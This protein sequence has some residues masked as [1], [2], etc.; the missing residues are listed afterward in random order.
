MG[1]IVFVVAVCAVV[2]VLRAFMKWEDRQMNTWTVIAEGEFDHVEVRR[3]HY[4]TRSGSMVHTTHHHVD[5]IWTVHLA[6]G[7]WVVCYN[8][9][10]PE[11]PKG[12]RVRTL[13]NRLGSRKVE[14]VE[15]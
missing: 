11:W 6:D 12:T 1:I 3:H 13:K 9:P 15:P 4:S 10:V 14:K 7:S 5:V 8:M 2:L